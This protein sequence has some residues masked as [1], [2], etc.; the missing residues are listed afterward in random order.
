M[1]QNGR[2]DLLFTDYMPCA[3]VYQDDL[4]DYDVNVAKPLYNRSIWSNVLLL[5][6]VNNKA[7][8]TSIHLYNGKKIVS[9]T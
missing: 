4:Q 2:R 5:L 3:T 6:Y 1:H 7:V 8:Y 9:N